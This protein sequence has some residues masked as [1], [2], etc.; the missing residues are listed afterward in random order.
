ME[1]NASAL[2]VYAH[3]LVLV[4][5]VEDLWWVKDMGRAGIREIIAMS[6][7]VLDDNEDEVDSLLYWP[8]CVLDGDDD[9]SE[10][11]LFA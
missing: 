7:K 4:T 11:S 3:W 6:A 2:A 1:S 9:G 8:Q 5:L 10:I